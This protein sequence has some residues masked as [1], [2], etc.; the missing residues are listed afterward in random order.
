MLERE[1]KRNENKWKD[2]S[3]WQSGS[4]GRRNELYLFMSV[5]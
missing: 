2:G 1:D 5:I 3:L 4:R